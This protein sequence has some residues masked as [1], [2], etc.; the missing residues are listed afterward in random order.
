[1]GVAL[2]LL[3]LVVT[4]TFILV[5]LAPGDPAQ[6]LI[7]PTASAADATR[8]RSELGLDRPLA[9]QYVWWMGGVLRG[10][11]GESFASR[12]PVGSA[13]LDALPVSLWL[14]G[15]ALAL[16]F[17]VGVPL[18]IVQAARRGR[19]ADRAL[20]IATTLVYAAPSYWL[21]LALVAA[22]T[23]GAAAWGLP[24]GMRPPA[25]GMRSPRVELH[26]GARLRDPAR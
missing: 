4:I 6:L 2:L 21:A 24:P 9:V 10:N 15:G 17:L 14:G 1:M 5:R 3:W 16:T 22:F 19:A 7:S 11:L 23:Y 20:T 13:L 8:L 26:D 18:G 12:R 25:F